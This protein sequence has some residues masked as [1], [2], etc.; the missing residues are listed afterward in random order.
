[1]SFKN[2]VALVTGANRGIGLAIVKGLL[3]E[4][5]DKVYA[6]SRSI[7]NLPDFESQRVVPIA[8]DLNDPAS[9][10]SA[11][12][13]ADDVNVL[14]NNAG[15]LARGSI[16]S[17]DMPDIEK[18]MNTNF[19]GALQMIRVFTPVIESR[20]GG[21]IVNMLS[22]CS[23]AGM[24]GLGGYCASK[25]ALYSATQSLQPELKAR[26]I[27]LHGVYPGPVATD[28]N[29]DLDIEMASEEGVVREILAGVQEG[30]L[31]I[32]PDMNSKQVAKTWSENPKAIAAEFSQY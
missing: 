7:S 1:M 3:Q 4:D 2:R 27:L 26:S 14:I 8:L 9:I 25:A 32:F 13:K 20:G 17:N 10:V 19:Y 30:K 31:E 24:P 28:M 5:V 11:A 21:N 12:E 16:L 22:I 6:A 15:V 18:E 23:Y 29:R